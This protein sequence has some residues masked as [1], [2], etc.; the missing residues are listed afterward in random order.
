MMMLNMPV[1]TFNELDEDT[2]E[3]V[4]EQYGYDMIDDD[5]YVPI[6][7]EAKEMFGL[8]IKEFDVD[9]R[10]SIKA[11]LEEDPEEC[12]KEIRR[13]VSAPDKLLELADYYELV[14]AK[15]Y[16]NHINDLDSDEA[17]D[18]Y[19]AIRDSFEEDITDYYL[20]RLMDEYDYIT[21]KE[22]IVAALSNNELYYTIDGRS[23]PFKYYEY[24]KEEYKSTTP[25]YRGWSL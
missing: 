14:L 17:Q 6:L 15:Y 10:R 22:Y 3:H 2:Q 11:E 18:D 24:I 5:W 13:L 25:S 20:K 4:I 21:S 19:N 1:Y 23:I 8:I 7:D 16:Y 9:R 12:V